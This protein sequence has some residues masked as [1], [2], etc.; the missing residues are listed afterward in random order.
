MANPGQEDSD[1]DGRGDV[2]DA[3]PQDPA[4]DAD[5]DGLGANADNCPTVANSTQLDW[6]GDGKGDACDRSSRVTLSPPRRRGK[7][8]ALRGTLRPVEVDAGAWHVLL[9]RRVCSGKRCRY[10]LLRELRGARKVGIGAVRLDL[11]LRRP[12]RYRLQA[13]L[14]NPRYDRAKSALRSISVGRA[15]TR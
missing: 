1:G 3:F 13:V 5:G 12:G 9:F 6:D 15:A 7:S 10:V 8:V 11:R 14:R 4:N 2:C